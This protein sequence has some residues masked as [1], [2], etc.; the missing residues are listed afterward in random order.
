[1]SVL[2][3]TYPISKASGRCASTDLPFAV[4]ERFVAALVERPGSPALER[5]DFSCQAWLNGARPEKPLRLFGFWRSVYAAPEEKRQPLLGDP[6]LLDLFEELGSEPSGHVDAGHADLAA[7]RY[8]LALLLVR[9]RVLRLISS[10]PDSIIVR[11]RRA[12]PDH[13]EPPDITVFDPGMDDAKMKDAIDQIGRIVAP[14]AGKA[15]KE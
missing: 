5:Q 4:G 7:F 2:A 15:S 13:P 11:A 14:E 9:R 6:E 1:M 12:G 3:S 8:L 10:K